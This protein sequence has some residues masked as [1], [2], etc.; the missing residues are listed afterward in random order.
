MKTILE[1]Y[2]FDAVWHFTDKSNRE[3]IK[4]RGLLSF[5]EAGKRNIEIPVPGGN[6]W[7]HNADKIKG[8]G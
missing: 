1:K 6:D 7:S 8:G 5:A 2:K 4:E 3:S